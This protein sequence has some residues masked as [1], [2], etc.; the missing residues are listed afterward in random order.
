MDTSCVFFH[1]DHS[2]HTGR[3]HPPI[4]SFHELSCFDRRMACSQKAGED[5]VADLVLCICYGR[6]SVF[7]DQ[8]IL[9]INRP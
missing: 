9:S 1:F 5:H 7:D 3:D 2:H 6:N 8:P 4:Y